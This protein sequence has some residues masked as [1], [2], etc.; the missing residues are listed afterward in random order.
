MDEILKCD[1]PGESYFK[2]AVRTFLWFVYYAAQ[3]GL[4]FESKDEMPKCDD[5]NESH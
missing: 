3:G 4:T 1:H 5:A 2:S